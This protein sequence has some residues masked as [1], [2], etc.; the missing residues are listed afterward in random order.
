M[1]DEYVK[2][3]DAVLDYVFDWTRWLQEGETINDS[4]FS[5]TAGI[6]IDSHTHATTYATVW[7]SGGAQRAYSVSN[8][9]TTTQ[10]RTDKRTITIKVKER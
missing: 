8:T 6:T 3:P 4:T 7:L 10:G 9:I 5:A 1:A 2:A